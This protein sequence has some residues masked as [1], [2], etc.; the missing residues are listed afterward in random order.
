MDLPTDEHLRDKVLIGCVF[1]DPVQ[2]GPSGNM[3]P[4]H[5]ML[6]T[7]SKHRP[8]WLIELCKVAAKRAAGSGRSL[9]Q[10]TDVLEELDV[11]G[12]RRIEDT[13][14][15]FRSQCPEV[16]ELLAA[17]NRESEEYST[18]RLLDVIKRKILDHITPHIAGGIG[19]ARP[20]DVAAFLFEIGFIFGRR[21]FADAS[22]EHISLAIRN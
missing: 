12:R 18:D 20:V 7:L 1:Q 15:E 6:H 11:F 17:F 13:V 5:V 22:Y 3:C 21:E 10:K 8:R 4:P 19:G 2:W 9:I 14:A 16:G